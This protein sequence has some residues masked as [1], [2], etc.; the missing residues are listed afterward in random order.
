MVTMNTA[1]FITVQL[2]VTFCH[3]TFLESMCIICAHLLPSGLSFI[4]Q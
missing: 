3:D 2:S 1:A 4:G